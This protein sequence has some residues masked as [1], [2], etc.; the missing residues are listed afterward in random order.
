MKKI[1]MPKLD[2]GTVWS[3]VAVAGSLIGLIAGQKKDS[4]S[5]Q[6]A[7]AEAA[8]QAAKIVMEKMSSK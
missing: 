2:A 3:L 5:Q 4:Y 1:E 6:A 7:T 8:E